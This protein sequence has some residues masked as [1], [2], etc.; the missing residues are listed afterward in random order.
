MSK[1]NSPYY[2]AGL[3]DGAADADEIKA[4]REPNGE[5]AARSWSGM[6]RDGYA[7]GMAGQSSA[8]PDAAFDVDTNPIYV[9]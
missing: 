8:D 1:A 7:D 3:S 9:T 5:D 6:Y 2:A 4:G